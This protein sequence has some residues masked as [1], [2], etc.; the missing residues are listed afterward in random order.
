MTYLTVTPHNF[1]SGHLKGS[2]FS[3]EHVTKASTS[4][5]GGFFITRYSHWDDLAKSEGD[6][7]S[8][9]RHLPLP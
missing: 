9:W 2:H 6:I 1:L 3:L 7:S 5:T 8:V 4:T